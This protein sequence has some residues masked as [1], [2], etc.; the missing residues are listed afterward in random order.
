MR[1]MSLHGVNF[2]H[3][4]FSR[5]SLGFSSLLFLPATL[6]SNREGDNRHRHKQNVDVLCVC[7]CLVCCTA[8]DFMQS[9]FSRFSLGLYIIV[10]FAGDIGL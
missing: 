10:V 5:V 2:V 3:A 8:V 1:V 4:E 6:G 9:E 7:V